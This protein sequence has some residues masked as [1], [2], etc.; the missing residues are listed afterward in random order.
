MNDL[1]VK[2]TG[3]SLTDIEKAMD[4]D[5]FLE[6]D[7]ALKF[8]IVDKVFAHRPEGRGDRRGERLGRRPGLGLA[9]ATLWRET[10][11]FWQPCPFSLEQAGA[12]KVDAIDIDTFGATFPRRISCRCAGD[13]GR[14]HDETERIRQQEHPL[15]QLLREVAARGAQADRGPDR[16][17]LR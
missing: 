8:G 17:H 12:I 6:A 10:V 7:E 14:E 4:R 15:L 2:Y 13:Y 9:A 5:T 3:Q 11:A 16:V 1:Y